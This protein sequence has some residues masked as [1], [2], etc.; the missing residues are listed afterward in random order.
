MQL[1]TVYMILVRKLPVA[2][3]AGLVFALC[4]ATTFGAE[5]RMLSTGVG[6]DSRVR[7]PDYSLLII[8]A[9]ANGALL[10]NLKVEIK[11]QSGKPVATTV[12]AGP[13][14]FV[15]L[16][17]GNYSVTAGSDS[18]PTQSLAVAV[19]GTRQRVLYVTW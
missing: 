10:A 5:V 4:A 17:E 15:G 1:L 19:N 14:L 6:V 13:W 9:E 2:L 8:F 12:S 16:P 7:R 3:L 11:D 18:R